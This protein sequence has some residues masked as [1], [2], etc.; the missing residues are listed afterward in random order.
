M[1][2]THTCLH[3]HCVF[4]TKG[5]RNSIYQDLQPRLHAYLGGI[6]K[7]IGGLPVQIG[8]MDDHVHALVSLPGHVSPSSAVG[9][10][11]SNSSKWI[12]R[13]PQAMRDFGWQEGYSAFTVSRSNLDAVAMYIASQREHHKGMSFEEELAALFERHG[14]DPG[15][16]KL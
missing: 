9:R 7:N 15:Q 13:L 12:H 8:G 3:Y 5:R 1:G 6:V 14:I 11:K 10:M 4:G 16:G 2:H